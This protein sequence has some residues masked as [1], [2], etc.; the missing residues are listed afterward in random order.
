MII[1]LLIDEVQEAQK[2]TNFVILMPSLPESYILNK[3]TLKKKQISSVLQFDLKYIVKEESYAL[4][5]FSMI[6]RYLLLQQ[7]QI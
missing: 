3:I 4:N 5:N 2:Y 1:E 7:I 6:G